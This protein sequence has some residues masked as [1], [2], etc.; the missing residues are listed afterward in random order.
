[1]E[2]DDALG[3][4]QQ[5]VFGF[6][7][8]DRLLLRGVADQASRVVTVR[9]GCTGTEVMAAKLDMAITTAARAAS[10]REANAVIYRTP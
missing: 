10:E 7:G 3:D 8:H 9:L 4:H 1:Q 5:R 2:P 6:C